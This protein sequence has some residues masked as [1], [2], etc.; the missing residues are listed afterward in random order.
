MKILQRIV[1]YLFLAFIFALLSSLLWMNKDRAFAFGVE[2]E[3]LLKKPDVPL[4][5]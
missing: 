3:T 4:F 2:G 1:P 5:V